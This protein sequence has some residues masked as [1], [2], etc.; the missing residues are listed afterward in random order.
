MHGAS[1]RHHYCGRM[2]DATTPVMEADTRDGSEPAAGAAELGELLIE[3][4][5]IDGTCGVY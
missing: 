2:D 1:G 4:I 3:E 5:S